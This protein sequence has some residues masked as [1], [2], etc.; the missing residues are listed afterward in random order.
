VRAHPSRLGLSAL[1]NT[2]VPRCIVAVVP[3]HG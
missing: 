3:G 2:V 1:S